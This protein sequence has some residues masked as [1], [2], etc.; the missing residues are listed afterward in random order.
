[1]KKGQI[2]LEFSI[3]FLALLVAIIVS[4]MIPGMYGYKKTIETSSASMGHAALSKLKT[5][6]DML[7]V[8]DAGSKK[9]VF[10]KSPPA[11]WEIS[12]RN[13]ILKGNG[14]NITTTCDIDLTSTGNYSTNMGGITIELT[15]NE[16]DIFINWT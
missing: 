13:I 12:G 1:M 2:S 6:I 3:L 7:S 5:N 14:Y 10:V 9:V 4:T 11:K 8:A 16:N 15:R